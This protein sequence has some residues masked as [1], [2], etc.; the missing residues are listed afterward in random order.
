MACP[1]GDVV[2]VSIGLRRRPATVR[3]RRRPLH[4]RPQI[5][6]SIQVTNEY[7]IIVQRAALA[8]RDV[9]WIDLLRILEA[10]SQLDS[11]ETLVSFGPHFERE[12]LDESLRRL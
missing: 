10:N 2:A 9:S 3:S 8:E 1:P 6:R 7:G 11:N 5:M 12:A 4:P